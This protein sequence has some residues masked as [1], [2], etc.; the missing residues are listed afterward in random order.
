MTNPATGPAISIR[1]LNVRFGANVHAVKDLSL[2]VQ[3][4]EVFGFVGPN[5]AGKTT[6]MR[7]L[8]DLLRPTTG[9]VE[10]LGVN[11]RKGG[12]A[13]RS[14]LGYLPGDVAMFP[15]LTG[16]QTLRF[17]ADLYR[18]PPLLRDAV[19][20]RLGFNRSA[21]KRKVGTYSTGMRQA[22]GI[23]A[24]FQH[25][26]ELLV[27]DEPTSGLDPVVRGA[28]L[29]LVREHAARGH[30]VFLSSHVLAEVEDCA[31]RVALIHQ[32]ELKL[33]DTVD[34]LRRRLPHNV[35][36]RYTDGR[37][38]TFTHAGTPAELAAKLDFNALAD[39]QGL[40]AELID[41]FRDAVARPQPAK[42]TEVSS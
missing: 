33:M 11:V 8:L 22:L 26:P 19:I 18:R 41:V 27:L 30:T 10:V 23:V 17:F 4:G 13:L 7:S 9:Q 40:P 28:F 38:E 39:L 36:L 6:T 29:E 25:D 21:L 1:G 16:E 37:R 31:H 42:G 15:F 34:A 20:D 2:E 14:R 5:G 32:G 12:S 35:V 24:A 3:R